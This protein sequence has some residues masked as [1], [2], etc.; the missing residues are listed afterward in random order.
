MEELKGTP[1]SNGSRKVNPEILKNGPEQAGTPKTNYEKYLEAM[2]SLREAYYRL[3]KFVAKYP[4]SSGKYFETYFYVYPV[5]DT[6]IFKDPEIN[7]LGG[8]VRYTS[9]SMDVVFDDTNGDPILFPRILVNWGKDIKLN[10]S[11]LTLRLEHGEIVPSQYTRLPILRVIPEGIEIPSPY[12]REAM[13]YYHSAEEKYTQEVRRRNSLMGKLM[14]AASTLIGK[15]QR[16]LIKPEVPEVTFI[17][18]SLPE[19]T[20]MVDTLTEVLKLAYEKVQVRIEDIEIGKPNK[21]IYPSHNSG[22]MSY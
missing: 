18:E 7:P 12:A 11:Y 8:A 3:E 22:R 16:E 5:E 4:V 9:E 14:N 13:D 6:K 10:G 20:N 1:E 17:D 19:L 2:A 21:R 15:P